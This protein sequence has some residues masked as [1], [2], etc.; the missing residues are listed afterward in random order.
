MVDTKTHCAT[1][2]KYL[3][4]SR[5]IS[6]NFQVS[7]TSKK[8]ISSFV[9]CDLE[10]FKEYPQVIFH[11]LQKQESPKG[12]FHWAANFLGGG[13]SCTLRPPG[14]SL[15]TAW[16][17]IVPFWKTFLTRKMSTI[18]KSELY[19]TYSNSTIANE[20]KEVSNSNQETI[21]VIFTDP[22]PN[23]SALQNIVWLIWPNRK[24]QKLLS[25]A[26]IRNSL[27]SSDSSRSSWSK[28]DLWIVKTLYIYFV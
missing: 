15:T 21:S 26:T 17:S 3:Y 24:I 1:R 16:R 9:I 18:F 22:S 12:D 14:L 6:F 20:K 23:P 28:I 10:K 8:G 13:G 19:S 2:W 4:G 7:S 11:R 27:C 25:L 5:F